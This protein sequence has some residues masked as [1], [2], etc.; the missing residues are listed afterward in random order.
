MPQVTSEQARVAQTLTSWFNNL[1]EAARVDALCAVPWSDVVAQWADAT[2]AS[3]ADSGT[4]E[5]LV[6]DGAVEIEDGRF[7]R[8][9]A[10]A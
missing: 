4:A 1:D 10:W 3:A 2:G 6:L 9:R 8:T 7:L 5:A